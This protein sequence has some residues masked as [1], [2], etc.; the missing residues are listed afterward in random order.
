MSLLKYNKQ[1]VKKRIELKL[2]HK[3]LFLSPILIIA[4]LFKANEWYRNYQLSHNGVETTAKITFVSL[5]GVHDQFEIDN[6]AFNFNYHDSVITGFTTAETN[7]NYVLLPNGMPLFVNDEFVVKYV[8]FHPD[9]YEID[10]SKPK[11]STLLNY[12]TITTDTLI[13]LKYFKYS[14]VQKEQCFCL[15]KLVYYKYGTNGLAIILFYNE[16]IANNFKHNSITFNKFIVTNEF[17]KL[18]KKCQ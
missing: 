2:W 9:I 17:Q 15:A 5:T 4:L 10:Y 14:N 12:I 3:L 13:K 8:N 7:D 11:I 16:S 18:F 6:V 1:T